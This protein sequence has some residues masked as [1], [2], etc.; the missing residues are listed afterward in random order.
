MLGK[1]TP[2][3]DYAGAMRA[4]AEAMRAYME[5]IA[6][7]KKLVTAHAQYLRNLYEALISAGFAED[8]ALKIVASGTMP[9]S[10]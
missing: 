7:D 3:M 10:K 8:Q 2:T 5:S 4:S 6:K 1:Q 9:G